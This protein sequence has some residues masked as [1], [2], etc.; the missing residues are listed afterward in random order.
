MNSVQITVCKPSNTING[1]SQLPNSKKE[2]DRERTHY[3]NSHSTKSKV[4]AR[5]LSQRMDTP[6]CIEE[7]TFSGQH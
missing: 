4:I 1:S 3:A 5:D 2:K 7:Y 6:D